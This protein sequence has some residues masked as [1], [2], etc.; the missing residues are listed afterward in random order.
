MV[1]VGG[2]LHFG[3]VVL[4]DGRTCCQVVA[5]VGFENCDGSGVGASDGSSS[6]TDCG[7]VGSCKVMWHSIGADGGVRLG[8]ASFDEASKNPT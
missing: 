3:M 1:F 5:V 2:F 6:G 8:Y 4:I 7:T